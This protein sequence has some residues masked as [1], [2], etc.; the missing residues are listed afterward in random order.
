[1]SCDL[2]SLHFHSPYVSKHAVRKGERCIYLSF[3]PCLFLSSRSG[4][5]QMGEIK[6]RAVMRKI[7]FR[8][9]ACSSCSEGEEG[10]RTTDTRTM[11]L[12][13]LNFLQ[14][15]H[16]SR[17]FKRCR[18]TWGSCERSEGHIHG[19][20]V[21]ISDWER[22]REGDEKRCRISICCANI[23]KSLAYMGHPLQPGWYKTLSGLHLQ[24]PFL[25]SKFSCHNLEKVIS[26]YRYI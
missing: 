21:V 12:K 19:T 16:L 9:S 25:L 5:G 13:S 26:K 7:A 17:L 11:W 15:V 10:N 18:S 24:M 14:G 4:V 8:F 3:F 2:L 20:Y 23:T 6:K 22:E 1:M